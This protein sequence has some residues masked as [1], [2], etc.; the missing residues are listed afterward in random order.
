MSEDHWILKANGQL[1]GKAHSSDRTQNDGRMP[2]G[3]GT[4]EANVQ[5]RVTRIGVKAQLG[6][7]DQHTA[8]DNSEAR[9][10]VGDS[11]QFEAGNHSKVV[12]AS[13]IRSAGEIKHIANGRPPGRVGK[14]TL[15]HHQMEDALSSPFRA[16]RHVHL[17][18]TRNSGAWWLGS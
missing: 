11:A 5:G 13:T 4:C 3:Q 8:K 2:C 9:D 18:D 15:T 6:A 12:E 1:E 17:G 10:R 16:H 7:N 14:N